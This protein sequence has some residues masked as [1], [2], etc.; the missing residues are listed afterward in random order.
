MRRRD[1]GPLLL[2][3]GLLLPGGWAQAETAREILDHAKAVNDARKPKDTS[4]QVTM[5]IKDPSLGDRVRQMRTFRK[6]YGPRRAKTITY[7]LLPPTVKG[8]SFLSWSEPGKDDDQWLYLPQLKRSRRISAG[9]RRESFQGSDFTYED[10][11]LFDELPDWTEA[12]ATSRL[13]TATE[14]VDGVPCAVI[15]LTPQGKDLAYGR[16]E[17]A[18]AR[19]D[20]TTR[21]LTL[22]DRADGAVV[23]T[24][25]LTSFRT[26]GTVPTPHRIEMQNVKK[27][28]GTIMEFVDVAYDRGLSDDLFTEQALERPPSD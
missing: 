6:E 7:F 11:Q 23:K 19:D 18:V 14:T 13:V 28:T 16:I 27:K 9:L 20:A 22:Y 5:T 17:R 10:L 8:V 12:D 3:A 1:F 25:A 24:V 2:I 4:Q 26:I 15:E 21:R